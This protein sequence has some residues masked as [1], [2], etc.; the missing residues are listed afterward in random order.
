VGAF[1]LQATSAQVDAGTAAQQT[2]LTQILAST[3]TA[4]IKEL[5]AVGAT[6]ISA[7]PAHPVVTAMM[8]ASTLAL[9][10]D[11]SFSQNV[12]SIELDEVPPDIL[13]LS[14]SNQFFY[15]NDDLEAKETFTANRR[16][17]R[18]VKVG[19][20]EGYACSIWASNA[21]FAGWASYTQQHEAFSINW[22][23]GKNEGDLCGDGGFHCSPDTSSQGFCRDGLCMAQ[24][25]TSVASCVGANSPLIDSTARL[26]A[27][28]SIYYANFGAYPDRWRWLSE[29]DV[30]VAN[31]SESP[32]STD[33]ANWFVRNSFGTIT[34][35]AGNIYHFESEPCG[36]FANSVCVGAAYIDSPVFE[37]DNWKVDPT[38]TSDTYHHRADFV[39]TNGIQG[40]PIADVEKP[41]VL[42]I[43]NSPVFDAQTGYWDPAPLGGT[44]FAA[45]KVAGLVALMFEYQPLLKVWPEVVRPF[46]MVTAVSHNVDGQPLSSNTGGG[47]E[48][49]GAGIPV[50]SVIQRVQ[51]YIDDLRPGAFNQHWYSLPH[52][53]TLAEGEGLRVAL[54]WTHCVEGTVGDN[55]EFIAAD[56]DLYLRRSN[57]TIVASSISANNSLEFLEYTNT[58]GRSENITIQIFQYGTWLACGGQQ[59][60]N[61]GVAW[62]KHRNHLVQ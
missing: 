27:G 19:I 37:V 9:F 45:P 21:A 4:V 31:L 56:F 53:V 39:Y 18:G 52:P 10:S 32:S 12:W 50:A 43:H 54:G 2:T 46:L 38:D 60:E 33:A 35:A 15:D 57:G 11:P 51:W 13:V 6:I 23:V 55:N 41:D 49:D 7:P 58:T 17:A 62:V 59:A 42:A 44:S 1:D 36:C 30:H 20:V 61:A 5:Q 34:H 28:A 14:G 29:N 16:V 22:C 25:T 3:R 24:H 48:R 40:R 47:D 8:P 26:A